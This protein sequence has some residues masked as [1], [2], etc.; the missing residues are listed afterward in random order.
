MDSTQNI[1]RDIGIDNKSEILR[2]ANKKAINE[3][4]KDLIHNS[5]DPFFIDEDNL[6]LKENIFDSFLE[7]LFG[8]NINID[9]LHNIDLN[10][11]NLG[12][13]LLVCKL[14]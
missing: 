6:R 2:A 12:K 5:Q 14:K 11:D 4:S 10:D 9:N 8:K 7:N 13:R 1:E 3:S